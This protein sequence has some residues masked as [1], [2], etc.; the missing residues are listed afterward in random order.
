MKIKDFKEGQSVE[1]TALIKS[2]S[3]RE[4]KTNKQFGLIELSDASGTITGNLWDITQKQKNELTEQTI[5]KVI[6]KI[7]SFQGKIQLNFTS[8]E[9]TTGN[10]GDYVESAP[11]ELE[12]YLTYIKDFVASIEN[13][14]WQLV[15]QALMKKYETQFQTYPAALKVH[16][17]YAGGLAFHTSTM[18]AKGKTLAKFYPWLNTELLCVGILLHDLGKAVEMPGIFGNTYTSEG[19]LLG[20]IEIILEDIVEICVQNNIDHRAEDM[21]LLKHMIAAHHGKLEWGTIAEPRIPE[22]A[23]LHIIDKMDAE[24]E[25]YRKVYESLEPGTWTSNKEFF[26]GNARVYRPNLPANKGEEK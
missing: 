25:Q 26:L 24:M 23:M 14:N 11:V 13:P 17:A 8:I 5:V 19:E 2:I 16:H 7:D 1:F 21:L 10:I 3:I 12:K 18:L 20:H 4:T 22:A 6:G 9:Q 15:A